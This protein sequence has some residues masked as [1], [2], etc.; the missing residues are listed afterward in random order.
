MVDDAS[1]IEVANAA[2]AR[3]ASGRKSLGPTELRV[4]ARTEA[5]RLLARGAA[6]VPG[7]TEA[8]GGASSRNAD[9]SLAALHASAFAPP[10]VATPPVATPP[11]ASPAVGAP[12]AGANATRTPPLHGPPDP[13]E[14]TKAGRLAV[15]LETLKP[16]E[17]LACVAY[18]VDGSSVDAIA[19]LLR[20]PRAHA[21]SILEAA[22]PV[23]ARATGEHELPDFA[24]AVDEV[25]VVTT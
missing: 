18:F 10:P 14:Q 9:A 23:L 3:V 21:V 2:L 11:L 15:A 24:A 19:A 16:H 22:S 5:A 7:H 13:R 4:A 20:V 6:A 25:E 8:S 1:A 12:T 17:R